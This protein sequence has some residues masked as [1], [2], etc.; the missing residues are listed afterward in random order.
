MSKLRKS[1][2]ALLVLSAVASLGLAV[3]GVVFFSA[4]PESRADPSDARQVALGATVYRDHCARCHGANLE[5]QPE[6][7][8]RKPDGRLPAPPHDAT[9]HT[10]H[11]SDE[12]LFRLTKSGVVP[13]IAPQGYESDMP[14]FGGLLSDEEIWAVLA[15]IKSRWPPDIQERQRQIDRASRK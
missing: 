11:H 14:G 2:I 12:Q 7:Q 3:Y 1:R 15:Y 9:G 8:H 5:G 6:W 10:W 13:P 4:S